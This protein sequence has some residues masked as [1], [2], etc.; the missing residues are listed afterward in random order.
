MPR[1]DKELPKS[2]TPTTE[3]VN[4]EPRRDV[5]KMDKW[6]PNLVTPRSDN[7]EPKLQ[8]P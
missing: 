7:A 4:R 6:L 3:S 2:R 8:P 1:S 5:P